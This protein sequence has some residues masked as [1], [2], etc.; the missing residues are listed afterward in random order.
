MKKLFTHKYSEHKHRPSC[1]FIEISALWWSVSHPFACLLPTGPSEALRPLR[2]R[3]VVHPACRHPAGQCPTVLRWCRET[4]SPLI[5]P[6]E[7]ALPKR[8]SLTRMARLG[9]TTCEEGKT[10]LKWAQ[11]YKKSVIPR[12]VPPVISERLLRPEHLLSGL[13]LVVPP[14]NAPLHTDGRRR[15]HAAKIDC[16]IF[17]PRRPV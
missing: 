13:S 12:L 5:S 17:D 6:R 2:W 9:N 7:A 11:S 8:P 1:G 15:R 16:A 3:H 4:Q 14:P 10:A